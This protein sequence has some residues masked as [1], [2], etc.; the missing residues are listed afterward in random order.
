MLDEGGQGETYPTTEVGCQAAD[1]LLEEIPYLRVDRRRGFQE[2]PGCVGRER[3]LETGLGA[4][5]GL[6]MAARWVESPVREIM[7]LAW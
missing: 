2:P 4:S 3:W 6:G 7:P 1:L 5:E